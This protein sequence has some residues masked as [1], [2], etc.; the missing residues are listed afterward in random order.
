MRPEARHMCILLHNLSACSVLIWS[1][2]TQDAVH[3]SSRYLWN[4]A[5]GTGSA[6]ACMQPEPQG[7]SFPMQMLCDQCTLQAADIG[8]QTTAELCTAKRIV[9]LSCIV[10]A[11]LARI[12]VLGVKHS[13][14][15]I[16]L[17]S[18]PSCKDMSG[19]CWLESKQQVVG[20]FVGAIDTG[21]TPGDELECR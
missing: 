19:A 15:C 1:G 3:S 18:M 12:V 16:Y 2:N 20:P 21:A 8:G 7:C 10:W 17:L 11:W 13:N 14:C 9:C 6:A 5:A 4:T